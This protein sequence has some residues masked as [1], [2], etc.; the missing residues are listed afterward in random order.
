MDEYN[1]ELRSE[2]ILALEFK[3]AQETATQAQEDRTKVVHF[4]LTLVGGLGSVALALTQMGALWGDIPPLA[5]ALVFWLMG[6]VGFFTLMKLVRLRQAWYDSVLTMNF[7]KDHY[8]EKFQ[9][10][11]DVFRW[12]TETIPAKGKPWTITFNLSLL[13][14]LL[15]SVS[16]AIGFFFLDLAP[17]G[18]WLADEFIVG[19]LFFVGQ[20]WWYFYQLGPDHR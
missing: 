6:I 8:I 5:Y 2:T 9:E 17:F 13:V 16:L 18:F 15:D 3:Y 11:E 1:R 4:Y 14:A 7:I 10:L 20:W 12:K 19:L